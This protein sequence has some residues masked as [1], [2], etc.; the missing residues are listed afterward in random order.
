MSDLMSTHTNPEEGITRTNRIINR[1]VF[2]CLGVVSVGL[3][4]I[5]Y[6]ALTGNN[7][8]DIKVIPIPVKPVIV[9]SEESI[10]LDVSYCKLTN[11]SGRVIQR[12]VSDKTEILAPT[13]NEN[14][15]KGCYD[16]LPVKIP[17]PPQ[18]TPGRYH[19]NYRVMYNTNPL[20]QGLIEEYN[21]EEFEVID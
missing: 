9:K 21:S 2:F 15:P 6:W 3:G 5:F 19:V 4:V 8:L 16:H 14:L 10:T 20:H 12:L 11:A 18:T 7:A 13:V 17:I 1:A